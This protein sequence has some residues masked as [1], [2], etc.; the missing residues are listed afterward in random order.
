MSDAELERIWASEDELTEEAEAALRQEMSHRSL[1][2]Q[3]AAPGYSVAEYSGTVT[4]R[5]YRDLS[6]ALLA[7]GKL[8]AAG[9]DCEVA[10]SNMA[11]MNWFLSN[12][13]GG[14]RIQVHPSDVENA[15]A[16]LDEPIPESLEVDG[17]GTV[18][19][20]RCPKCNSLDITYEALDK[21]ASVATMMLRIPI[22][23][24]ADRWKCNS[25][26]QYWQEVPDEKEQATEPE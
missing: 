22:P 25:C 20:P 13:L 23:V 3:P 1:R 7:K 9:I 16:V 17:I 8:D 10:D 18:E 19:Q 26:G 6:E 12:M 14:V 11:R 15:V 4:V 21:A 5:T 2:P 24:P